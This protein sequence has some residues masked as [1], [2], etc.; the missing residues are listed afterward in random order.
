MNSRSPLTFPSTATVLNSTDGAANSGGATFL[1][2][3]VAWS[4]LGTALFTAA[5]VAMA[6]VAWHTAKATLTASEKASRAAEKANDQARDDSVRQTRPYVYVEV[7]P[8]LAGVG[9]F[10]LR[11][12]NVGKSPARDLVLGFDAWPAHNDD[13]VVESLREL[14]DTPRTLP[15]GCSLRVMWRLPEDALPVGIKSDGRVTVRYASDDPSRPM[16]EDAF[17]VMVERSGLWPVGEEGPKPGQ[18]L[19]PKQFY[20]LGQALVRRVSD[21]GR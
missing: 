18:T 3:L 1:D 5:L 12:A 4:A 11:I 9:C 10:D 15:P 8:G 16:Y 21:L 6:A 13:G 19:G 17:D 14:F 7:V 20:K 2:Q